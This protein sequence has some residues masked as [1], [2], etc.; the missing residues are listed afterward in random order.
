MGRVILFTAL[1]GTGGNSLANRNFI[2]PLGE[3]LFSLVD[4]KDVIKGN[5]QKHS[6]VLP[7]MTQRNYTGIPGL[8]LILFQS[9]LPLAI[10][11]IL[12]RLHRITIIARGTLSGFL[13]S[14]FP[15][16]NYKLVLPGIYSLEALV[17]GENNSYV[18]RIIEK[19][20]IKNAK[21][22]FVLGNN[23]KRYL[24]D[25]YGVDSEV[26]YIP[27]EPYPVNKKFKKFTPV[28]L[29]TIP[30]EKTLHSIIAVFKHIKK[31]IKE[32]KPLILSQFLR[33]DFKRELERTGIEV[34]SMNYEELKNFLPSCHVGLVMEGDNPLSAY[35]ITTKFIDYIS[36]GLPVIVHKGMDEL[37]RIVKEYNLGVCVAPVSIGNDILMEV[38]RLIQEEM[39]IRSISRRLFSKERF[40]DKILS[41]LT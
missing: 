12:M 33:E 4:I 38:K 9:F 35:L 7:V 24:K 15:W 3:R 31:V 5:I 22:V 10:F 37:C 8:L 17:Y 11:T 6:I 20:A 27:A 40:R 1:E 23:I 21:R 32:S 14:I 16:S 26:V 36:A 19:R 25:E 34:I 41:N 13:L 18:N 29:G 39:R 2:N 28:H 30:D